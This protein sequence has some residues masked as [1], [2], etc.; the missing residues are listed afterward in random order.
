MTEEKKLSPVTLAAGAGASVVS[1]VIGSLFGDA[2]T[3]FGAALSSITYSVGA[4]IFEDRTRK[5]HAKLKARKQR[6]KGQETY[7]ADMP[8]ERHIDELR[9]HRTL[10]R[11]WNLGHKLGVAGGLLAVTLSACL[12]TLVVVEHATGKTLS[13]NLGGPVQY[14]TTLGGYSTHS[15]SPAPVVTVTPSGSGVSASPSATLSGSPEASPDAAP[16]SV[17][18]DASPDASPSSSVPAPSGSGM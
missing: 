8:L 11:T 13:S 17:T 5:A 9:A 15:P 16:F 4:F 1:M 12:V 6:G 14:G 2:G 7:L 10:H 18:P 3:L